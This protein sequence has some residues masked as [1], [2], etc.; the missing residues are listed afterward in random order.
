MQTETPPRAAF[1]VKLEK[2]E[3]VAAALIGAAA[4]VYCAPRRWSW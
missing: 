4:A 1:E 2:K 3:Y